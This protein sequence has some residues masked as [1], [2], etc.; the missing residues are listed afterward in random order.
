MLKT[1]VV[2]LV[3]DQSQL[4]EQ[5][6]EDAVLLAIM[7][8]LPY[9]RMAW[10]MQ[11]VL[12]LIFKL[13]HSM[14]IEAGTGNFFPVYHAMDSTRNMNFYL[15]VNRIPEGSLIRE[16]EKIDYLWL[17]QAGKIHDQYTAKLIHTLQQA[18]GVQHV[19]ELDI[20]R[21]KD[22]RMLIL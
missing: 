11:Q 7:S 21:V 2:K 10:M 6:F 13:D 19:V 18:K 4:E 17:I 15:Y 8:H 22:R 9:Y 20:Q 14:A 1:K 5:F 16:L 12:P 3:L